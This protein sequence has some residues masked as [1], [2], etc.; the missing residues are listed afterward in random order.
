MA[1]EPVRVGVVGCGAISA[2]YFKTA[3][4][5]P[6]LEMVAC[7]DLDREKAEARAAEFGVPRVL[8]VDE[9]LDD[10]DVEVVL[11]LTVPK[12]HAPMV[13]AAVRHVKHTFL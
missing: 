1:T 9:L 2:A 3:A 6:V 4:Q 11:N 10:P 7:A 12:A 13:L 5:L 8:T